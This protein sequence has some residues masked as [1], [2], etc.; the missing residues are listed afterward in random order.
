LLIAIVLSMWVI[1]SPYYIRVRR[2]AGLPIAYGPDKGPAR[3]P[4]EE[5]LLALVS[6]PRP[7]VIAGIGLAG[8]V[9]VLWLMVLKPS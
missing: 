9:A 7:L 8:L 1:A 6:S 3:P 4:D 5:E 2:A